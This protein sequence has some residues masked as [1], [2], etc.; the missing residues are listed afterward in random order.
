MDG[1][2]VW[3]YNE[4]DHSSGAGAYI[5]Q[6]GQVVAYECLGLGSYTEPRDAELYALTLGLQLLCKT[7]PPDTV[8]E[9]YLISDSEWGLRQLRRTKPEPGHNITMSWWVH[10]RQ[11]LSANPHVHLHVWWAKAR[12]T[13]FLHAVDTLA[14]MSRTRGPS[15][16]VSLRFVRMALKNSAFQQWRD[17]VASADSSNHQGRL[18]APYMV[19]KR[20]APAFLKL[21]RSTQARFVQ[22]FTGRSALPQFL[23]LI[24]PD[25]YSDQC[26]CGTG[27]GGVH[28][29]IED[30]PHTQGWRDAVATGQAMSRG[31]NARVTGA[32]VSTQQAVDQY[33]PHVLAL[34]DHT[35]LGSDSWTRERGSPHT[36]TAAA[37]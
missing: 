4:P 22:F 25:Q 20:K 12:S 37:F 28:H 6:L 7:P 13:P 14:R 36:N 27:P 2:F 5:A 19:P 30:C 26:P 29:Y 23:G 1:S 31:I 16:M 35:S 24:K 9:V 10:A 17:L 15:P 11:F 33:V 3:H 8:K 21:W 34:L 32:M 18:S